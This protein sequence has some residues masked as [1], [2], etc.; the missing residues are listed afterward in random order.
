MERVGSAAKSTVALRQ[1]TGG[2]GSNS[3]SLSV[4]WNSRLLSPGTCFP[5]PPDTT[6]QMLAC[7]LDKASATEVSAACRT[8]ARAEQEPVPAMDTG[9]I[10]PS[11]S[12]EGP[13]NHPAAST[14]TQPP[15][16]V[17]APA[18][19]E[20]TPPRQ[21]SRMGQDVQPQMFIEEN[22]LSAEFGRAIL[23]C[24]LVD[25]DC[26]LASMMT[27]QKNRGTS[28][29]N[30]RAHFQQA[31]LSNVARARGEMRTPPTG[32][33]GQSSRSA[34]Q[35]IME[36]EAVADI[37][38]A[39]LVPAGQPTI[40]TLLPELQRPDALSPGRLLR[41]GPANLTTAGSPCPRGPACRGPGDFEQQ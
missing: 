12:A 31:V 3:M 2:E 14:V 25:V 38:E 28:F 32:R 29:A 18:V 35:A 13:P 27:Q 5:G 30:P 23:H 8:A 6:T 10:A 17:G 20:R 19:R 33:P 39:T 15:A 41:A 26:V 36:T 16:L 22:D 34:S 4:R 24:P 1:V 11:S 21:S 7:G 9:A 37:H 40:H